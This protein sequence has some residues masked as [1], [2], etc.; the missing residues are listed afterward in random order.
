MQ[1]IDKVVTEIRKISPYVLQGLFLM[2]KIIVQPS[3]GKNL[4]TRVLSGAFKFENDLSST[5]AKLLI[6]Q[7]DFYKKN[8]QLTGKLKDLLFSLKNI[9]SGIKMMPNDGISIQIIGTNP[10]H[11]KEIINTSF[12]KKEILQFIS[13]VGQIL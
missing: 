8:N 1:M 7:I 9:E 10:A 11:N 6:E 3:K 2:Y 4:L 13:E 5:D 12:T